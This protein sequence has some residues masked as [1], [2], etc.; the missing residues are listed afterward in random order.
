MTVVQSMILGIVQGL[1]EFLPVSS[2]G[3]L[4]LFPWVLGWQE[5]PESFDV[6]LHIGTLLAI[7]IYFWKDWLGLIMGGYNQ[8][9]KK[10]PSTEGKIFWYIVLSTI[11][12]GILSLVL[13]KI[14]DK[15]VGDNLDLE[16]ILIAIALIVLGIVLYLVDERSKSKTNYEHITF[17]QSLW[18]ACS[19]AIAAAFPG[20]SRSGITMTT[21]R[22]LGVDRESAAKYSF[23][24]ATPITLAAVV[25]DLKYFVFDAAFFIGVLTSF[26]VGFFVIKFLM[27]YLKKG[28]FKYFAIYR[29]VIGLI[30]LGIYLIR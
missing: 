28:S 2:S 7:V 18:I 9:I 22:Y 8:T 15:I 1:T 14:A 20:T 30:V 24:L 25:F 19:Q 11:P 5:M 17:K 3:H 4:N 29:V 21:A 16:M 13:D 26:V 10:K 6:A 12:A 27:D 23:L